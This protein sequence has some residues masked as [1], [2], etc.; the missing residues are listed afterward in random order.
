MEEEEEK[1]SVIKILSN[2]QL[3]F[4]LGLGQDKFGIVIRFQLCIKEFLRCKKT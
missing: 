1:K 3:L 4:L 2:R